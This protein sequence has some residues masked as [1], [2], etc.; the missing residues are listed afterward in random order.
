MPLYKYALKGK[1]EAAE[2]ILNEDPT[3]LTCSITRGEDTVLHVAAGARHVHFVKKLVEMMDKQDLKLKDINGNTAF[4]IAAAAGSIE[5]VDIMMKKNEYLP[6]IRGGQGM[7]PLYMA[8]LMRQS[9][10][11]DYLYSGTKEM[12]DDADRHALFFTCI[13]NGLYGKIY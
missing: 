9:E 2:Q 3:L 12:L 1:W 4:S 7:T 5:I 8:A 11:A 13:D 10:M 6:T